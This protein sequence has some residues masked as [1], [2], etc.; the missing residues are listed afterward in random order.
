MAQGDLEFLPCLYE[1]GLLTN[2]QCA[3]FSPQDLA[4]HMDPSQRPHLPASLAANCG[5]M[6]KVW[7]MAYKQN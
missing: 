5:H 4:R 7:P 6:T 3:F 2:S 1:G